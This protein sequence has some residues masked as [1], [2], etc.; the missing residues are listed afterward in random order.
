MAVHVNALWFTGGV[1]FNW[2]CIKNRLSTGLCQSARI[3]RGA[4]SA[5]QTGFE[6][7][8]KGNPG[9]GEGHRPRL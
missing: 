9:P 8:R 2:K 7:D 5:P 1:I 4:Y 6:E 3:L